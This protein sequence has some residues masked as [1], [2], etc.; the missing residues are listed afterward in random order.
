MLSDSQVSVLLIQKALRDELPESGAKIIDLDIEWE[1]ISQESQTNPLNPVKPDNLAY[2]IYTSGSTGKPKGVMIPHQAINNHTVWMQKTFPLTATDKVLQKTPF[3]FDASVWELFTPLSVGAQLYMAKPG[4]H[5]DSTYLVKVIIDQQITILQ[6]VPSLLQMLLEE[7]NFDHCHSLKRLFCG[8][9][10]L[11]VKLQKRF[12]TQLNA[13]LI[14]LY[15][16]TET[17]IDATFFIC[18]R[19]ESYQKIPIGS[20]IDNLQVHLLDSTLKP[21]P[22]GIAGEIYISGAGLA[23]GYLNRPALTAEKFVSNP[24]QIPSLKIGPPARREGEPA[25]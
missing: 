23:R 12:L 10:S 21:V 22:V 2:V 17:C 3:N 1:R 15:G 9:E 25:T 8:G 6:T 18:Q 4:G 16:P 20:P 13:E 5:Q 7:P 24:H 11:P 19:E 14:N